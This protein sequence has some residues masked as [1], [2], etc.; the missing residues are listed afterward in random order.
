MSSAAN[1]NCA[2]TVIIPSYHS[3]QTLERCLDGA[4]SQ[5][6]SFP[7]QIVVMHSGDEPIEPGLLSRFTDVEFRIFSDRL[8]PAIKRNWAAREADTPWLLFLDSDCVPRSSWLKTMLGAAQIDRV[9]AIGGGVDIA[10]PWGLASWIMHLLEFG[11]WLPAAAAGPCRDFPSCNALYQRDLF[12]EAGGFPETFL[13]C[14]DTILNAQ[15]RARGCR[16]TFAPAAVVEHIHCRSTAEVL[17]HNYNFG[18]SYGL[19]A[20]RYGLRGKRLSRS[21]LFVPLVVAGRFMRMVV[22]VVRY[23]PKREVALLAAGF[24][25]I[26]AC[27]ITW[28]VGFVRASRDDAVSA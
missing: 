17:R 6:T 22:R 12:I 4:T 25:L 8:L 15:L 13:P 9:S 19:A 16:L 10:R 1:A 18:L 24:P 21:M 26:M 5:Q 27:L 23:R 14:E 28:S 3:A 11:E 2:V 7:Y 20:R